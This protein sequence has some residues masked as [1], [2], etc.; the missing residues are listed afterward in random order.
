MI[1]KKLDEI[2]KMAT[3]NDVD[4]RNLYD[5]E[6]ALINVITLQAGEALK[7]HITPENVVFYVL[8]GT[9]IVEVGDEKQAVSA[10]TVI[11]S[12][13]DIKHCWYNESDDTLKVMV[14]KVPRPTS[15]SVFV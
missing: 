12:P 9:G 5:A 6:E 10:N 8:T 14:I 15:K 2:K 7:P 1:V 4:V 13:K 11:E 3:A